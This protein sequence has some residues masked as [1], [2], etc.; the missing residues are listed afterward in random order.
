MYILMSQEIY[1]RIT[2][3]CMQIRTKRLGCINRIMIDPKID[4]KVFCQFFGIRFRFYISVDESLSF[5]VI[6]YKN[7]F[8]S[9]VISILEGFKRFYVNVI[10]HVVRLSFLLVGTKEVIIWLKNAFF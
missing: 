9:L 5:I 4:K 10:T 3:N 1:G 2:G 6:G 7:S 8:K